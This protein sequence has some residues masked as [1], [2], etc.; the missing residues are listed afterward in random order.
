MDNTA[1]FAIQIKYSNTFQSEF[2]KDLIYVLL[3]CLYSFFCNKIKNLYIYIYIYILKLSPQY[4]RNN[5]NIYTCSNTSAPIYLFNISCAPKLIV[6]SFFYFYV[7]YF[8][9]WQ[10]SSS[11]LKKFIL[12]FCVL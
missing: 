7:S 12:Y 6:N 4:C 11:Y 5:K 10:K 3:L 1:C 9:E 8:F 2:L